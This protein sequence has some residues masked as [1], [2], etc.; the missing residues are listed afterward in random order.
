M[1]FRRMHGVGDDDSL[2]DGPALA[3]LSYHQFVRWA[4]P[5]DYRLY[6]ATRSN[7]HVKFCY[8]RQWRVAESLL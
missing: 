1:H 6:V 8:H 3:P 2:Q 5:L 4:A 7:V